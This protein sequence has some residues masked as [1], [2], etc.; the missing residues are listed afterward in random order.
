MRDNPNGALRHVWWTEAQ[1]RQ[2]A[3]SYEEYQKIKWKL[4]KRDHGFALIEE[5]VSNWSADAPISTEATLDA[6]TCALKV[7]GTDKEA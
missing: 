2:T 5:L 1:E 6:I 7:Y 4:A 3:R